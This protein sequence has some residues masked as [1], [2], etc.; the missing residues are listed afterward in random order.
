MVYSV[1]KA[2]QEIASAVWVIIPRVL[3][4]ERD[5]NMRT[6]RRFFQSPD[7]VA[8]AFRSG[9]VHILKADQVRQRSVAKKYRQIAP[10][11]RRVQISPIVPRQIDTRFRKNAFIRRHPLESE[12]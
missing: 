5:D 8:G 12:R 10:L 9:R 3:S 7:K 11:V 6:C 4:V 1:K 2:P